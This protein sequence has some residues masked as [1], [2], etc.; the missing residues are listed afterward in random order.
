MWKR[1][2]A[3]PHQ[4]PSKGTSENALTTIRALSGLFKEITAYSALQLEKG[5][6]NVEH[7][8]VFLIHE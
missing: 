6:E 7:R 4:L 8:P 2:R 3:A 5:Q 1:E